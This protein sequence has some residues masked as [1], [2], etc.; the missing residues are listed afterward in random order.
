MRNEY[1]EPLLWSAKAH[2]KV[3]SQEFHYVFNRR[4]DV[5]QFVLSR[6]LPLPR[7]FQ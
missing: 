3:P 2:S 6:L 5:I 4:K 1:T 7:R